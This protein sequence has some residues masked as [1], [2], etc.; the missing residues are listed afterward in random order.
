MIKLMKSTFFKEKKTKKVLCEFIKNSSILSMNDNC[1]EFEKKFAKR[2][3]RKHAVFVSNGSTAN[4]ALLQALLNNKTLKKGDSIGFSSLTWATNVMPIIQ[5]G[6]NPIPIDVSLNDLNVHSSNILDVI[7]NTK[8]KAIFITNLLGFAGDLDEIRNLCNERNILLLEDN[9]ESL[10]S[11]INNI[12][13]GN[14][15]LASTFSFFVGHH[16]STIEGGMICTDDDD[17]H[18]HLVM[19]RS[20]GW[21]RNLDS[22]VQKKLCNQ[23]NISE[24]YNRYTFYNLAYNI[25]PTEI[26]AIIGLEQLKYIKEM[27]KKRFNNFKKFMKYSLKNKSIIKLNISHLNFVSNFAFPLIFNTHEECEIQKEKFSRFSEIR[28]IVG[29]SITE[30][31]FFI[32]YI[33]ENN[34]KINNCPN[35]VKIHYDGFYIPNNPELTK[36]EINDLCRAISNE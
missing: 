23:H 36:K 20:H 7:N 8:L 12:K 31:P 35:A 3:G 26:N 14:F 15:G 30:Q 28:P 19:I 6:L 29:G 27:N 33:K 9:C 10:D 32:K 11:E 16:L 5:L 1:S 21:S 25:R 17:L 2:Q 24:F 34:I 13:L 4:L 22:E 18:M